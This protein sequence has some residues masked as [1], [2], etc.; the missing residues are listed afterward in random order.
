MGHG[1]SGYHFAIRCPRCQSTL[2]LRQED[3]GTERTCP[4][5]QSVLKVPAAAAAEER[6][7]QEEVKHEFSFLCKLCSTR[8]Y[9]RPSQ[10]GQMLRCPDCETL[11]L[12]PEPVERAKP[13]LPL[14]QGDDYQLAPAEDR[15]PPVTTLEASPPSSEEP[16][17][18]SCIYCNALLYADADQ[19][20]QVIEC[21]DCQ[22]K[23][24]IP[25]RRKSAPK[26]RVS[27]D[28]NVRFDMSPVAE[29]EPE[30]TIAEGLM[31]AAHEKVIEKEKDKP[32]PPKRPFGPDIYLFPFTPMVLAFGVILCGMMALVSHLAGMAIASSGLGMVIGLVLMVL[33]I[34]ITAATGVLAAVIGTNIVTWAALGYRQ[35]V[36]WP[37][38]E[39]FEWLRRALF[40]FN[41]LAVSSA[42]GALVA[43]CLPGGLWRAIFPVASTFVLFPIVLLSMVSEESPFVPFS[44]F[45]W[46]SLSRV[47][48]G[49]MALYGHAAILLAM[50]GLPVLLELTVSEQ[51]TYVSIVVGVYAM[52]VYFRVLGRLAYVI[53][54]A[55]AGF[56]DE[57]MDGEDQDDAAGLGASG[58]SGVQPPPLPAEGPPARR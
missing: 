12:V 21:P 24:K 42:P 51:W 14:D 10:I 9:G 16:V 33:S 36:E 58:G 38:F 47:K 13:R 8:L 31:T 46:A 4:N 1:V 18:F 32:N 39:I 15:P 3:L 22:A 29:R 52:L 30:A 26:P 44:R 48:S 11:N 43:Y 6:A 34:M 50:V 56:D 37:A 5:C 49:W 19:T 41:S 57:S 28:P 40:L 17:R 55:M 20:G 25:Q 45:I 27:V 7:V 53:D 54:E 2:R 35:I 23:V